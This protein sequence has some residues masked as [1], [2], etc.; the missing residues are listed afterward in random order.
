[1]RLV[2]LLTLPIMRLDQLQAFLSVAET[3]SFQKAARLRRVTQSTIS[4]QVRALEESVGTDLLHRTTPARLTIAGELLLPR[5]RRICNEWSVGLQEIHDLVEGKQSELC[6]A[7]I[8]SVCA[9]FLPPVLQQ[10]HQAYGNVQLRVTSLGSDRA[11]KVLRDGL[12]DIAI[13]MNNPL[14]TS[15]ADL[16]IEPL[17]EESVLV[18]MAANH[19]L[20]EYASIPQERLAHYDH[21]IFKDGYGMQRLVQDVFSQQGIELRAMLELNTL[22]A[23]RGVVRQSQAIA[24]LPA[25]ATLEADNDPTLTVRPLEWANNHGEGLTRQVVMVTSVDRLKIPPIR[26]FCQLVQQNLPQ[27]ANEQLA[28]LPIRLT[29]AP[30][31][32]FVHSPDSTPQISCN[33]V[34]LTNGS[35]RTFPDSEPLTRQNAILEFSDLTI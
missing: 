24:I 21:I 23:F 29:H 27:L 7:A 33:T 11:L 15:S 19:P 16:V 2:L 4:R 10:F 17:Y 22:D 34:R 13:V 35:P 5:A 25:S 30:L 3:G 12:V 1:M 8:H 6:V 18:L 9:H 28:K 32:T 14:L 31:T 20:A 26:D